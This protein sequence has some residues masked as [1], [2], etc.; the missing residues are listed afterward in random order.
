MLMRLD[1]CTVKL[2]IHLLK[3]EIEV[4]PAHLH[5][6]HCIIPLCLFFVFSSC[7]FFFPPL[8]CITFCYIVG[9]NT[10]LLLCEISFYI[11]LTDEDIDFID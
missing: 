2:L 10:G 7:A 1:S 4:S 8:I 6:C 9:G 11:C 3:C 5:F